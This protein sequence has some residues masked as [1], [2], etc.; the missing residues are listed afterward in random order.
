MKRPPREEL[1][2]VRHVRA[3]HR[4]AREG[5]RDG[6]RELDAGR[7]LAPPRRA[8]GTD[9]ARPR[10]RGGRRT[11][12]PPWRAP[13]RRCGEGRPRAVLRRSARDATGSRFRRTP[14]RR[15][16][17]R[18]AA[19]GSVTSATAIDA[20]TGCV[21]TIRA[22]P[23]AAA[24][25]ADE[26]R[27]PAL[28]ALDRERRDRP[29]RGAGRAACARG[30]C[31][32]CTGCRAGRADRGRAARRRGRCGRRTRTVPV[33]AS[34]W[35]AQPHVAGSRPVAPAATRACRPASAESM[36]EATRNPRGRSP[37]RHSTRSCASANAPEGAGRAAQ[38]HP[39]HERRIGR[40]Q[41]RR[42]QRLARRGRHL[43][44][45]LQHPRARQHERLRVE[46]VHHR[47]VRGERVHVGRSDE[48]VSAPSGS[49]A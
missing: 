17:R 40:V 7:V 15:G 2:V 12:A 8:A 30:A 42:E 36:T 3:H 37:L 16:G 31:S 13:R 21:G 41:R 35:R 47:G 5:D 29:G 6:G 18:S 28:G 9:R 23:Q 44:R 22:S 45:H 11:P 24:S 46:A 1:E 26:M 27:P 32:P 39:R 25:N 19:S 4:V 10:T 49:A 34:Y 43:E 14:T 33:T 20:E 48:H 38:E